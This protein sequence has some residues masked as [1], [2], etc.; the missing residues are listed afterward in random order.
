MKGERVT[1]TPQK[2]LA[3]ALSFYGDDFTGSTDALEV[4]SLAG[5]DARLSLHL[6]F[7][8]SPAPPL[9][10]GLAGTSRSWTPEQMEAELP[11]IFEAMRKIALPLFHIKI[12]STF[13]SAP[14]IGSIGKTLQI[15]RRSFPGAFVPLVVGVPML[16]R[17]VAFGNLF[18]RTGRD[19]EVFRID[20]HPTMRNHPVTPLHEADL[21]RHLALQTDLQCGL[22]DLT[23]LERGENAV[24]EKI[25]TLVSEGCEIVLFDTLTRT[26]LFEIGNALWKRADPER[27][28]LVAGSSGVEYALREAWRA[29]GMLP[30]PPAFSAE[31]VEQIVVLS[32]SCSPAAAGQIEYALEHGFGEVVM[33]T[34]GLAQNKSRA[35]AKAVSEG[36]AVLRAGKSVILHTA[37]GKGD[38]RY[39]E[40]CA[41]LDACENPRQ[42]GQRLIREQGRILREIVQS[43]GIRRIVVAGGDT[44]GYVA[45][46]LGIESL[47]MAAP[48]APGSPLCRV[49]AGQSESL[50]MEVLFK[51]G[52]VGEA[53][54]YE[55]IRAGKGTE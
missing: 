4:L 12:C 30:E 53:A 37:K 49:V 38:P 1:P 13:D 51:G 36:V 3:P 26:H 45:G 7:V 39:R 5:L 54:L 10:I 2:G 23:D 11:A 8:P 48:F 19:S 35:F 47:E 40:T 32:G 16:N 15:A 21:R 6:P 14:E 52:Q 42:A 41:F 29:A 28:L 25:G 27:P 55:H 46:E 24:E 50:G 33:D 34:L 20:R 43:T 9:S 44:S 22:V 18:A 17:F 31:P